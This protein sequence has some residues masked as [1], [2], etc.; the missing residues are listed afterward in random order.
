MK[1]LWKFIVITCLSIV[2]LF[3]LI[4]YF[5]SNRPYAKA[6]REAIQLAKEYTGLEKADQF[7]WYSRKKTYF[8]VTGT[9]KEGKQIVVIIPQSGKKVTVLKQSEGLTEAAAIKKV[10]TAHPKNK[11][12]K[13]ALGMLDKK[14]VW[15]ITTKNADGYFAYYLVDFHSGEIV[16]SIENV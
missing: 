16:K 2:L 11:I 8:S 15:E 7:Y 1:H 4:F 14:A 10:Q 9:D 5:R 13:T 6:Q 12:M 3:S